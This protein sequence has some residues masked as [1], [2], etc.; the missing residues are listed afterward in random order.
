MLRW[1]ESCINVLHFA[2]AMR[3]LARSLG[4]LHSKYYHLESSHGLL[5]L[6]FGRSGD[7]A[8]VRSVVS[9]DDLWRQFEASSAS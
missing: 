6:A 5:Q 8:D 4:Y 7:L 2:V 3:S 9:R 1:H